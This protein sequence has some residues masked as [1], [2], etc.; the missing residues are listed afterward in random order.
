MRTKARSSRRASIAL[1]FGTAVSVAACAHVGQ[2]QFDAELASLRSRIE[3]GDAANRRG[4]DELGR[5]SDEQMAALSARLDGLTRALTGLQGQFDVTVER[6]ETAIR[7]AVPVYFGFDEATLRDADLPVLDHFGSVVKEF[8][9]HALLTVEG[10]TDPAGSVEYNRRLGLRRAE[11][12]RTY[13]VETGGFVS[14]QV[15]AVSYGEDEGRL[16]APSK[17]GRQAG[18][19]NRRVALVVDHLGTVSDSTPVTE[20]TR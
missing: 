7:F 10:F 15:R 13:L 14:E 3:Q 4:V 11:A 5:R 1:A 2:D 17:A 6:L 20:G 12:V 18:W 8:Y 9:P 16:V 19:E